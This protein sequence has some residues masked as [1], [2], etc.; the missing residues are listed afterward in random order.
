[1]AYRF[2]A[3]HEHEVVKTLN[4]VDAIAI[5]PIGVDYLDVFADKQMK[6]YQDVSIFGC[7]LRLTLGP[8]GAGMSNVE[9]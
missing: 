1:M 6:M 9:Y 8:D 2:S 7:I 5:C 3:L 4:V